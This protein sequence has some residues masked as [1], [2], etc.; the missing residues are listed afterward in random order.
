MYLPILVLLSALTPTVFASPVPTTNHESNK[1]EKRSRVCPAGYRLDPSPAPGKCIKLVECTFLTCTLPG[2]FNKAF[3]PPPDSDP[4]SWP[5]S[6]RMLGWFQKPDGSW[7]L[8]PRT[9]NTLPR[10]LYFYGRNPGSQLSPIE[11]GARQ[12][13]SSPFGQS[14]EDTAELASMIA[15]VVATIGL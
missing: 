6:A 13:V 7:E 5:S 4:A 10:Q 2:W 12:A 8:D 1:L 3:V 15:K 9:P 11:W 14:A